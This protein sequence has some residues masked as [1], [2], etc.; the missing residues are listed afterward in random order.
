LL[1]ILWTHDSHGML[2]QDTVKECTFQPVTTWR[3]LSRAASSARKPAEAGSDKISTSSEAALS[4]WANFQEKHDTVFRPLSREYLG[5][6][7]RLDSLHVRRMYRA[8]NLV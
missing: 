1:W 5:E 2:L 3:S 8:T 4:R 6:G 7:W